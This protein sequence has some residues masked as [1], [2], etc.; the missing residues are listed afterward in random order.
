MMPLKGFTSLTLRHIHEA[1][2]DLVLFFGS[3]P[4]NHY[5]H[6]GY[7]VYGERPHLHVGYSSSAS[8]Y[9]SPIW[10]FHESIECIT[11]VLGCIMHMVEKMS[12]STSDI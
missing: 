7:L 3:F 2:V 11:V 9:T 6:L 12:T 5:S 10:Y 1:R 4:E 8:V